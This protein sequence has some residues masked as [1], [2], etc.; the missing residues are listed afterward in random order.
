MAVAST[1]FAIDTEVAPVYLTDLLVFTHQYYL[2]RRPDVFANVRWGMVNGTRTL[3]FTVV[4]PDGSWYIDV[5]MKATSP[6]QVQVTPIRGVVP[7][8]TFDRLKEDL[9]I[10]VQV[11]EERVRRTTLYFAWVDREE[12]VP[13][14]K[15]TSRRR[16]LGSIF[17]DSMM[18]FYIITIL[19]SIFAF[20]LLGFYAPLVII[21]FQFLGFLFSSRIVG[22]LGSWR[23]DLLSPT[24]HLLQYHLTPGEYEEFAKKY[25][26]DSV[27]QMKREIYA[28]T[29]AQGKTPSCEV[30]GEVFQRYGIACLPERLSVKSINVYDIVRRAAEKFN[31]S[32]PKIVISNTIT[33]NAAA[34]GISPSRGSVLIT[35]GLLVQLE[36]DEL[37]SVVGHELG[38]LRS[39]DSFI[40]FG[41]T[42][43]EFLLRIYVFMPIF[44]FFPWVYLAVAMGVVY[45]VAK[46]FEARADLLSAITI[47]QPQVLAEALRKIGFRRLQF[48][49][50]PQYRAQGW[51]SWDPHPPTY[52]RIARLERMKTP[53]RVKHPLLQSTKDVIRGFRSAF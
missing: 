45:F 7:P 28:K 17:A 21:A 38:H 4:G 32:T 44:L 48:E 37:L 53:V 24:I 5:E 13:E 42:A 27:L 19:A 41:L 30:G 10:N 2:I 15:E 33:P 14:A 11:F 34:V 3:S 52:F 23:I 22:R 39:W 51:L 36:E 47:G 46:F 6:V 40:M 35:T 31:L 9:F 43:G 20:Q 12:I 16:A 49:R 25:S 26:R 29:L 18:L 8:Y 50:M 1:T